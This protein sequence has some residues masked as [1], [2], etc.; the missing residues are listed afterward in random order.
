[1]SSEPKQPGD[2]P[3][4]NWRKHNELYDVLNEVSH[5]KKLF[6]NFKKY[7]NNR[8]TESTLNLSCNQA[9]IFKYILEACKKHNKI[10][11]IIEYIQ[12]NTRSIIKKVE[13]KKLLEHINIKL[14]TAQTNDDVTKNMKKYNLYGVPCET[15]IGFTNINFVKSIYT[16]FKLDDK[17]FN[18]IKLEYYKCKYTKAVIKTIEYIQEI[19]ISLSKKIENNIKIELYDISV[20]GKKICTE[21]DY[22]TSLQHKKSLGIKK[23]NLI[24]D[25]IH[26]IID[27]YNFKS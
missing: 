17:S 25:E 4:Q 24:E 21:K 27:G 3:S 2:T 16:E 22:D 19:I 8:D 1:M 15:S 10:E 9:K 11:K 26:R 12:E 18:N 13:L 23:D 5:N 20:N 6:I 14:K 7:S